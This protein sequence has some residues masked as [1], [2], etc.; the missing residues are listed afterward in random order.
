MATRE[1]SDR[2]PDDRQEIGSLNSD[3]ESRSG[4]PNAGGRG[5]NAS[6]LPQLRLKQFSGKRRGHEEWKREIEAAQ[7]VYQVD[8]ERMAPLVYLALAPGDD[9]PRD[10]LAHLSLDPSTYGRGLV[11]GRLSMHHVR[12]RRDMSTAAHTGQRP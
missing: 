8:D 1:G 10:F 5:N 3:A 2:A 9:T 12:A 4:Y 11:L 7:Y 6:K